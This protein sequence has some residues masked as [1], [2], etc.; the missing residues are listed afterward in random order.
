MDAGARP[1]QS[2]S[3]CSWIGGYGATLLAGRWAP[4]EEERARSLA[5]PLADESIT[6][7][8]G[9]WERSL[10]TVADEPLGTGW[11]R[12]AEPVCGGGEPPTDNSYLKVLEE[13]GPLGALLFLAGLGGILDAVATGSRASVSRAPPRGRRLGRVHRLFGL[14]L[15]GESSSARQVIAWAR[16]A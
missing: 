16:W 10:E 11:A 6:T 7:R 15:M 9:T 5:I 2:A 8:L 12:S 13:Q 4:Q 3:W 1:T 14:M